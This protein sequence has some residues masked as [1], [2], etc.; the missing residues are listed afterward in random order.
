MRGARP[1]I[2]ANVRAGDGVDGVVAFIEERG[3]LARK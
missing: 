1:F 3:G 2:F